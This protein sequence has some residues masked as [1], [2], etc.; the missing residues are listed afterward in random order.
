MNNK[1]INQMHITQYNRNV[2]FS[3]SSLCLKMLIDMK[4]KTN[5]NKN[6]YKMKKSIHYTI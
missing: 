3:I 4:K 6:I 5:S 2:L 1:G